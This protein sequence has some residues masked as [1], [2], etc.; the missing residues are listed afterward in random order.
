[1]TPVAKA[2][3]EALRNEHEV[4]IDTTIQI[5]ENWAE[6]IQQE[7]T[8]ADYLIVLLSEHSIHSE[9][10]IAQIETAHHHHKAFSKPAILPVRL[11]FNEALVYPLSAYLNPLQWALWTKEPDTSQLIDELKD[12]ISGGNLPVH[13]SQMEATQVKPAETFPT[14]FAD[15]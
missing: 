2:V 10:V 5:G 1:D 15:V 7:I 13:P 12:A 9:M 11:A 6:R 4:F 14:A 3:Y 8:S